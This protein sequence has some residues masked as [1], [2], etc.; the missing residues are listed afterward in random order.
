MAD[1]ENVSQQPQE[2]T[3]EVQVDINNTQAEDIEALKA[4]V[5]QLTESLNKSEAERDKSSRN[6]DRI[7]STLKRT[8]NGFSKELNDKL[9][10]IIPEDTRTEAINFA[11][12]L[13]LNQEQMDQFGN[14]LSN[15]FQTRSEEAKARLEQKQ[16][17]ESDNNFKQTKDDLIKVLNAGAEDGTFD[18][19]LIEGIKKQIAEV[20][21]SLPVY[22]KFVRGAIDMGKKIGNVSNKNGGQVMN[23]YGF[24]TGGGSVDNYEQENINSFNSSSNLK[25]LALLAQH[26]V[27]HSMDP[28]SGLF[29]EQTYNE[30]LKQ[31]STGGEHP[32]GGMHVLKKQQ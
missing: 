20:P 2:D 23:D 22:A 32:T 26:Q 29:S 28:N 10:E 14:Y 11:K 6:T 15:E 8:A 3:S 19:D 7:I 27:L 30:L 5:Q 4:Q 16:A 24:P 18:K 1:E 12:K 31:V 17:Y 9:E 25:Q 21:E 13:G